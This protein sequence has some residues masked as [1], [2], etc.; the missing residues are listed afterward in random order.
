MHVYTRDQLV[1]LR[2]FAAPFHDAARRAV[3]SAGGVPRHRRLRGCRAGR[4]KQAAVNCCESADSCTSA[5]SSNCSI[6]GEARHICRG[7]ATYRDAGNGALVITGNRRRATVT[8]KRRPAPVLRPV[9][10]DRHSTTTVGRHLAFGCLNVRWLNNKLDDLLDVLLLVE[11][12]HFGDSVAIRRL[13]ADGFSVIESARPRRVVDPLSVNH[14]G[15]AIVATPGIH[16]TA[17]DIGLQPSTFE[18]VAARV[19]SATSSC[20]VAVLYLLDSST[21]TAAFYTEFGH[22]MDRL[23]SY[24]DPIIVAGD[25]NIRLERA[26]DPNTRNFWRVTV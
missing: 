12:W 25:V 22:L 8:D 17:I 20:I 13:R 6:S 7:T 4:R 24:V 14:G 5:P 19:V 21:L 15:V 26:C 2:R 18:V 23:S 1:A 9:H 10:V 3:L 11:T 16:L